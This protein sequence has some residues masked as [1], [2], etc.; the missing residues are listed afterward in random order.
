VSYRFVASIMGLCLVACG[1]STQ[2]SETTSSSRAASSLDEAVPWGKEA[3]KAA[4]AAPAKSEEAPAKAEMAPARAEAAPTKA[5][6]AP[7][8]AAPAPQPKAA[9]APQPKAAP[10]P[11]PKAA[12][13]KPALLPGGTALVQDEAQQDF[14]GVD[15]S[16]PVDDD[17]EEV[18]IVTVQG[19]EGTTT[20][21]DVRVTLENRAEDFDRCHDRMGGGGG[22]IVYRIH[23]EAD[24][25]VGRV[26]AVP[27]KSRNKKLVACYTEVVSSS[28][29]PRPHGGY[30]NAKWTTKV[31][32]TSRKKKTNMLY[33]RPHRWDAP[34]G[35]QAS[36]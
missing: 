12:A 2:V 10:A 28:R 36:R 6:A 15:T 27:L 21:F 30:A 8:K 24:G 7:T 17:T 5:D 16:A 4:R 23:I 19:I 31:G 26:K 33:D 35:Q 1:G 22:R 13:A 3:L 29:F 18:R 14:S 32:R 25:K 34:A 9:P 11:Q 20:E